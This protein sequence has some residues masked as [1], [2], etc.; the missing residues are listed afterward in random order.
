MTPRRDQEEL[1]ART[2]ALFRTH[3]AVVMQAA[4]GTGKTFVAVTMM[5]RALTKHPSWRIAFLADRDFLI[6]DTSA[7]LTTAGVKH[8]IIQAERDEQPEHAVQVCSVQTLRERPETWA[9]LR[10]DFVIIDEVHCACSATVLAL[11]HAHPATRFLGLTATPCRGDGQPLGTAGFTAMALGPEPAWLCAQGLLAPVH[12]YGPLSTGPGLAM[13]P[14]Q[15]HRQ[16]L[17]GRQTLAFCETRAHAA[18]LADT[19]TDAGVPSRAIDGRAG[20][21]VRAQ[22]KADLAAG[23][24]DVLTS[25]DL[26]TTGWDAPFVDG[27]LFARKFGGRGPWLQALGRGRRIASG[28]RDCVAVDL[29]GSWLELGFADDRQVWSLE[30]E[31][32]RPREV[33]PAIARCKEC[34]AIFKPTVVCPRCGARAEAIVSIP[35]VL[36]RAERLELVS[37]LPQ[38]DRDARYLRALRA[39]ADK[40]LPAAP[41]RVREA[42][43]DRIFLKSRGYAFGEGRVA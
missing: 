6:T 36:N 30:G 13:D 7:R 4:T 25:V 38:A 32:V 33:L 39:R 21:G 5:R 9:A 11:I 14:V 24:I 19:L 28:K 43:A 35:R 37:H 18:W 40:V 12:L 10:P 23:E 2:S 27:L 8:G 15:A 31:A 41:E 42:W 16:W 17:R 34:G 3:R 20:R 1:L 26:F 29:C 22:A